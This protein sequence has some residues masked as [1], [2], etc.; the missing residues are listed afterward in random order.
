MLKIFVGLIIG[1]TISCASLVS[2][3]KLTENEQFAVRSYLKT[4]DGFSLKYVKLI[5][6]TSKKGVYSVHVSAG[7]NITNTF[8]VVP[9]FGFHAI[10]MVLSTK[11]EDTPFKAMTPREYKKKV[12]ND[13]LKMINTVES[14]KEIFKLVEKSKSDTEISIIMFADDECVT[15][16]KAY[17]FLNVQNISYEKI[18]LNK[19]SSAQEFIKKAFDG[20]IKK[21]KQSK[22]LASK[23]QVLTPPVFLIYNNY[24]N[25]F[26]DVF[27]TFNQVIKNRFKE[28]SEYNTKVQ[29]LEKK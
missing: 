4:I 17:R 5:E 6:Y 3:N 13:Y 8:Y 23:L 7:L 15:C 20:D 10:T 24:E 19:T 28:I 26:I 29:K 14:Q 27:P 25:I 9:E 18:Y 21:Y 1:I 22:F 12:Q 2:A 16:K 11:F